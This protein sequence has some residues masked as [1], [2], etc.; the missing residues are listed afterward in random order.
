MKRPFIK[1]PV[2]DKSVRLLFCIPGFLFVPLEQ[3][4]TESDRV[5]NRTYFIAGGKI[6]AVGNLPKR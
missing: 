4:T 1:M 5:T 2:D 3:I 6:V